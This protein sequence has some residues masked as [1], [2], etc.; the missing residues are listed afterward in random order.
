M[1]KGSS[2][3]RRRSV[4]ILVFALGLAA[5]GLAAANVALPAAPASAD[6]NNSLGATPLM[7]WSNW[8][9]IGND[10]T[11]A[12]IEAQAAA[13]KN[14]GLLAAGYQYINVDD[15]YYLC[16]SNGPEVDAN[17]RWATDPGKF[18][19]SGST[20]GMEALGN[21]IHAEGE[22]FGMYVRPQRR[23]DRARALEH[24]DAVL[25][26]HSRRARAHSRHRH[27]DDRR[28]PSPSG[29]I[30][31]DTRRST[32]GRLPFRAPLRDGG[33]S[34]LR[35]VR[36]GGLVRQRLPGRGHL[37][38]GA[39]RRRGRRGM[40]R[41]IRGAP[42]AAADARVSIRGTFVSLDGPGGRQV[43]HRRAC[44]QPAR[45]PRAAGLRDSR[46]VLHSPREDDPSQH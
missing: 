17:G 43:C 6:S 1:S 11:T 33:Q 2:A 44:L 23:A 40:P 22:K 42:A 18:P 34:H 10:P 16:N 8:S 35:C 14:S 37:R 20:P 12:K 31:P 30:T 13:M 21:Y 5:S 26:G 29:R 3:P 39:Y 32:P 28:S 41:H 38:W 36:H 46:T 24:D 45:R 25:D 9:Y 15:F 4:R 27:T 19:N 7:G